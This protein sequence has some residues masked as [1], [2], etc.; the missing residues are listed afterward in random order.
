MINEINSVLKKNGI[1]DEISLTDITIT[2][3]TVSDIVKE[4]PKLSNLIIEKIWPAI[5]TEEV[6]H[7][8]SKDSAESILNTNEFRLYSLLKR[9]NDGEVKAFCNNH[10]LN[11]Y[12]AT[13]VSGEPLYQTELMSNMY[14]ASFADSKIT[15]KQDEYLWRTFAPVDGVRLKLKIEAS[16]DNFRQIVYEKSQGQGIQ[17]LKELTDEI[18]NKFNRD[19]ILKGISR[20]CAF[21]LEEGYEVESEYRM[22]HR[23]WSDYP[24]KPSFDG[25]FHYVSFPLNQMSAIGFKISVLEIQTNEQLSIPDEYC[26]SKRNV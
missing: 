19:F 17:L 16:S 8:T 21:Y 25:H 15:N 10:N 1:T 12:L 2:N 11:G 23:V 20:L 5:Q 24:V 26:V 3:D 18:K 22:L 14:Y 7:Y 6:Y 13:G 9:F 4:N